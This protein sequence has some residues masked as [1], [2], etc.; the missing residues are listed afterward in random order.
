MLM[1]D[2]QSTE[3]Y[4]FLAVTNAFTK[5][6]PFR[7]YLQGCSDAVVLPVS[8]FSIK[9]TLD[10]ANG[11]TAT[12]TD[13]DIGFE[14]SDPENCPL[15]GFE[16][17]Y[18]F[19]TAEFDKGFCSE[20]NSLENYW[21][22][23]KNNTL[24]L[25]ATPLTTSTEQTVYVMATFGSTN[26]KIENKIKISI[27]NCD[28]TAWNCHSCDPAKLT[29]S[30]YLPEKN[31]AAIRNL[32]G[33]TSCADERSFLEYKL[34]KNKEWNLQC[35]E[36]PLRRE[37]STIVANTTCDTGLLYA[38][39]LTCTRTCSSVLTGC[40]TCTTN[41]VCSTCLEST[42]SPTTYKDI[43]GTTRTDCLTEQLWSDMSITT[44]G[45]LSTGTCTAT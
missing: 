36:E 28:K 20:D 21:S 15:S 32:P 45:A 39:D 33:C 12:Y 13:T 3:A 27:K 16:V 22:T 42:F 17:R 11:E 25:D 4:N 8:D 7:V 38:D 23:S 37:L 10:W 19:C 24:Q 1:A 29:L 30:S 5:D 40:S 14:S 9:A 6:M 34:D 44:A 43:T 18:E 31:A 26:I 2:Q 35:S 41:L